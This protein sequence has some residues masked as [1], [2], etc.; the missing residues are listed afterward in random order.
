[1]PTYRS[2]LPARPSPCLPPRPSAL[3]GR[4]ARRLAAGLLVLLAPLLPLAAQPADPPPTPRDPGDAGFA[5]SAADASFAADTADY[6]ARLASQG[7]SGVLLAGREGRPVYAGGHGLADRENGQPWTP[8]TVSSVGSLTKQFTAAAIL[9]LEAEGRLAV[10]DPLSRHFPGVPADKAAITLHQLL[11]M[12]SGIVDLEGVGDYDPIDRQEFVTR[13]FAQPLAFAPGSGYEY[14]NANYSLLGALI[15]QLR[16]RPYEEVILDEL[17]FPQGIYETGYRLPIRGHR[18]LAQ[19][20]RD[21]ALWGTVLDRPM[22][23]DGPYWVLRANGG[24]ESTAYDMFRWAEALRLGRVLPPTTL[25][26][27]WAPHV[28][29]GA[30]GD[31]FYGYGWS[32]RDL[33]DGTRVVSHNGSNGILFADLAIVPT[34]GLVLFTA[35]NVLADFR[36]GRRLLE[37]VGLRW[38]A[39]QPY[40]EVPRRAA[41]P[42]ASHRRGSLDGSWRL[43][44]PAT[45]GRVDLVEPADG[46]GLV[47]TPA[48]PAAFAAVFS[49]QALEPA[50]TAS[51]LEATTRL[52]AAIAAADRA[53]IVGFYAADRP[54]AML[55]RVWSERLDALAAELGPI[56]GTEVL[57]VARIDGE[58]V[59]VVQLRGPKGVA[60]RWF[61][62]EGGRLLGSPPGPAPRALSFF[63]TADGGWASFDPHRGQSRR[64]EVVGQEPAV[65]LRLPVG[66]GAWTLVRTGA[67]GAPP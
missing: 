28:R 17:L 16:G 3:P 27:L 61:A 56:T 43:D 21:G 39:G 54:A 19:G 10:A 7:W 45:G 46:G 37:Q 25:T 26:R 59:S 51:V 40:P 12:S 13:I 41:A 36:F 20:Y 44:P 5:L 30:D 24:F 50:A 55:E 52:A 63:P 49:E 6:L 67:A 58:T 65:T 57:G 1:M 2:S 18:R 23:D 11:T 14:S 32:V 42:P 38:L 22:A 62:W 29:E 31:S 9:R 34:S 66:D 4:P 47:L 48:D 53:R 64:L 35:T 60:S 33:P 8:A 15:E